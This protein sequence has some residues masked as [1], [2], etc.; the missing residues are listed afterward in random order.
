MLLARRLEK[1]LWKKTTKNPDS[2]SI[3]FPFIP[4]IF[5]LAKCQISN[6]WWKKILFQM[7]VHIRSVGSRK[8]EHFPVWR[9]SGDETYFAS[10]KSGLQSFW[11]NINSFPLHAE[12][13]FCVIKVSSSHDATLFNKLQLFFMLCITLIPK[14]CV[15]KYDIIYMQ[16]RKNSIS[17]QL[18]YNSIWSNI[19]LFRYSSKDI[20][21]KKSFA[22]IYRF[23][24]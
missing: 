4:S 18:N 19:P 5:S 6:I 10:M 9:L 7:F 20:Y 14:L 8:I 16:F 17:Y 24:V 11:K 15:F 12:L 1:A 3:F 23:F 22:G 2:Y 21:I 13:Q